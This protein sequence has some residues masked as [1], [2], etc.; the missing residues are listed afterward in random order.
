[1]LF[2]ILPETAVLPVAGTAACLL[3]SALGSAFHSSPLFFSDYSLLT[4]RSAAVKL[5]AQAHM[6]PESL[7][8]SSEPPDTAPGSAVFLSSDTEHLLFCMYNVI[9]MKDEEEVLEGHVV[10]APGLQLSKCSL[11]RQSSSTD[12]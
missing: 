7:G 3:L 1:M 6:I 4:I 12:S 11:G 5:P 8:L 10:S 2:M 9:K